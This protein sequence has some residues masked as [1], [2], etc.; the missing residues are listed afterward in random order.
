MRSVDLVLSEYTPRDQSVEEEA[1]HVTKLALLMMLTR[2][3]DEEDICLL[4]DSSSLRLPKKLANT[5]KFELKKILD[6]PPSGDGMIE[7]FGVTDEDAPP[8]ADG[9][10]STFPPEQ[11][12]D[13]A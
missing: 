8:G 5:G 2:W 4:L 7:D 13:S 1:D 6:R 12:E 9:P 11:E 3:Y 10:S